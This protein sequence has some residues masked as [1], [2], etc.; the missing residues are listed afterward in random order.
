MKRPT[1]IFR[2]LFIATLFLATGMLRAAE[3]GVYLLFVWG[4]FDDATRPGVEFSQRKIEAAFGKDDSSFGTAMND[5]EDRL[6]GLDRHVK[7]MISLSGDRAH[8]ENILR[9]CIELSNAAGPDDA[10]M[11]YVLCNGG[12]IEGRDGKLRHGLYPLAKSGKNLQMDRQGIARG[13]IMRAIKWK[14]HRLNAL[15]TDVSPAT[16]NDEIKDEPYAR[17][18][19]PISKFAAS[20]GMGYA[21]EESDGE[22]ASYFVDFLLKAEGDLNVNS[23]RPETGRSSAEIPRGLFGRDIDFRYAGTVFTNAFLELAKTRDFDPDDDCTVDV[24]FQRLKE[25]LNSQ[26]KATESY[27]KEKTRFDVLSQFM[28]QETQ[29]LTRYDD[30][31]VAISDDGSEE[32]SEETQGKGFAM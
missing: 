7:R 3:P 30:D 27:L 16:V 28:N 14:P 31:G 19:G 21:E 15:I 22:R 4:N 6:D 12:S 1:L 17:S 2:A 29:T 26:Y 8:P 25:R 13:T 32:Y 5:V 24:F 9:T 23:C 20:F 11:V 18:S 10:V